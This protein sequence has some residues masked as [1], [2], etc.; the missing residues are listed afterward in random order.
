MNHRKELLRRSFTQTRISSTITNATYCL[1]VAYS[2][3][4]VNPESTHSPFVLRCSRSFG[5][6]PKGP[7]T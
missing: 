5:S 4:S 2:P 7:S 3:K 1:A 6:N